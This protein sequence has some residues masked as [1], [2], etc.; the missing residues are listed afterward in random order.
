MLWN[1]PM[2]TLPSPALNRSTA[3]AV[4][5]ACAS[6]VRPWASSTSPSGVRRTGFGPPGRSN[7][8]PPTDFSSAAICWLTADWV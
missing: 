4:E 2:S 5:A 8:A 3:S 6:R 1:V 7:T